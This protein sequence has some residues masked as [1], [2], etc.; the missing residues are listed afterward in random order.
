MS[1]TDWYMKQAEKYPLL[2]VDEEMEL[3]KRI[4]AGDQKAR[5]KLI[6]CNLRL[7]VFMANKYKNYTRRTGITLLDIVQEGNVGMIKAVDRFIPHKS[8][9]SVYAG[10]WI[11]AAIQSYLIKFFYTTTCGTDGDSRI[12]FFRSSELVDIA[13]ETD[14]YKKEEM[15]DA[16]V[17]NI[18]KSNTHAS[19]SLRKNIVAMERRFRWGEASMD[20]GIK[21]HKTESLSATL[22]HII[23]SDVPSP[24]SITEDKELAE[25]I[26]RLLVEEVGGRNEEIIRDRYLSVDDPTFRSLVPK[27]KISRQRID[28]CEKNA[29]RK[30]KKGL[31]SH[32]VYYAK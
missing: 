3:A 17:E 2:T 1:E 24:E 16:F 23:A 30:L 21:S 27:Y 22:H 18:K 31:V 19:G 13:T 7:V 15:I 6:N 26:E 20:E 10:F 29:L 25:T 8:K 14:P 32:G 12:I 11:R 28:Q 9:F 4:Q 5:E